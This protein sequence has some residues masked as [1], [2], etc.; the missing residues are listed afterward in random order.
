VLERPERVRVQPGQDL[1]FQGPV[2][3][4]HSAPVARTASEQPDHVR[5]RAERAAPGRIK[6]FIR[7]GI[8]GDAADL[9]ADGGGVA[10]APGIAAGAE[11]GLPQQLIDPAG[12]Q[13]EALAQ[14]GQPVLVIEAEQHA[15]E[16][17]QQDL[18]AIAVHCSTVTARETSAG[19]GRSRG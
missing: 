3:G 19:P 2:V 13:A 16:I 12:R 4:E 15:A 1:L 5:V 6:L 9:R 11:P 18:G 10:V 14:H 17:E 8:A 7:A